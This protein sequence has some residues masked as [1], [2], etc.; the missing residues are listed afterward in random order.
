M[1]LGQAQARDGVQGAA[2]RVDRVACTASG[3]CA[4]WLPERITL[5]EWG[6][7]VLDR[8]PLTADLLGHARRAAG[9]CPVRALQLHLRTG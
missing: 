8:T 4:G 2:L 1:T 3:L 7:P 5:D 6:Y 9:S